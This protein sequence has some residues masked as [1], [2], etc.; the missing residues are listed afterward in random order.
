MHHIVYKKFTK[1][2]TSL[3]MIYCH[4]LLRLVVTYILTVLRY[5]TIKQKHSRD[6]TILIVL[7]WFNIMC[8]T[9]ACFSTFLSIY[10]RTYSS[11][12]FLTFSLLIFFA[13]SNIDW[14]MNPHIPHHKVPLTSIISESE[15]S[16]T[17][18]CLLCSPCYTAVQIKNCL[19]STS[20][21]KVATTKNTMVLRAPLIV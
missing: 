14:L 1:K 4:I 11:W 18:L 6:I 16:I 10:Y 17:V 19:K 12:K 9:P 13:N 2:C 20:V 15:V 8:T 7:L 3:Y 5:Y 21:I